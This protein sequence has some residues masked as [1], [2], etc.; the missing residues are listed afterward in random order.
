[1]AKCD[2]CG[3]DSRPV[4]L[5]QLLSSYQ[6]NG[7]RDVCPHC[8]RWADKTK[9]DLLSEI[10]PKMRYAVASKK[11]APPLSWWDRLRLAVSK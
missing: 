6:I 5:V 4:E 8:A 9:A 10:S 1:M 2:L 11:G 7:V 3:G